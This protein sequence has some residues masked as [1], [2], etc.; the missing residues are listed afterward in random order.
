ML[1][2]SFSLYS[3]PLDAAL[4]LLHY[5]KYNIQHAI[6]D[7]PNY[8]PILNNYTK[9]AVRSFL[10]SVDGRPRKNFVKVSR[11][12]NLSFSEVSYFFD[13]TNMLFHIF[14]L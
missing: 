14:G 10:K 13:F 8:E 4:T 1:I 11:D 12:V 7:L 6:D 5:H 2:N 3:Y 9:S